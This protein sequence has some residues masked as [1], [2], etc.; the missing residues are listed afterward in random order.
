MNRSVPVVLL[1]LAAATSGCASRQKAEAQSGRQVRLAM[2]AQLETKGDWAG[3]FEIADGLSREDPE[4]PVALLIRGKSLRKQGMPVEAEFDLRRVVAMAPSYPEGHAEL[5][6]LCDVTGRPDE[7]LTHHREAS[8]L[9]P[10]SPRYLNN[11]G[12][13]LLVRGKQKEA[14][15]VLEEGLRGEPGSAILRNNLGFAFAAAGDF[16]R[17]AEQFRL[18]APPAQA[19]VN[20][21]FA[22]ERAGNLPQAYDAYLQAVRL[23]P[24]DAR[25]RANLGDVTR[26]LGREPPPELAAQVPTTEAKGGS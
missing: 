8:N 10:G 18:G 2:A 7:G 4:D 24:G 19:K 21:G 3:A 23:A 26:K 15:P 12:F 6:V 11:L 17:A 22:Y 16:P 25:A 9:A 1:A 20:L 13:A 14:I 5:A